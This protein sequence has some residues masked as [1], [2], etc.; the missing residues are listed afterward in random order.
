MNHF[1]MKERHRVYNRKFHTSINNEEDVYD[2]KKIKINASQTP[3][4]LSQRLSPR[5]KSA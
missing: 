2:I 4:H 5:Q 3:T 1:M